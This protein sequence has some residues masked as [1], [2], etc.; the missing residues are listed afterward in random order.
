MT[1]DSD[2]ATKVLGALLPAAARGEI[3]PG[4]VSKTERTKRRQANK[5]ARKTR[6]R[7]RGKK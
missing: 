1:E 3:Y 7:N 4:S 5:A 6:K 2:Y